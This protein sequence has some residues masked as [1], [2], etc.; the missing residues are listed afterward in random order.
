MGFDE[1]DLLLLF[2]M[3]LRSQCE[4]AFV[5]NRQLEERR[6]AARERGIDLDEGIHLMGWATWWLPIHS[7]LTAAANASLIL[8]GG[9][10]NSK[11]ATIERAR[12]QLRNEVRATNSS[13]LH[14]RDV[15]N[16]FEHF[17]DRL[18]AW[19]RSQPSEMSFI[20]RDIAE[21]R[22]AHWAD[23]AVFGSYSN[24]DQ[25]V[26]FLDQKCRYEPSSTKC[27]GSTGVRCFGRGAA[28]PLCMEADHGSN[29][30]QARIWSAR[31]RE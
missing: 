8:W 3:E 1:R 26:A 21:N 12:E 31:A 11:D 25:R 15:R 24:A 23:S 6:D 9:G 22:Q 28:K 4:L 13:P 30:A 7:I 2:R 17:D 18:V 10:H 14:G 19:L 27:G 16:S 5:A 20:S 29:R